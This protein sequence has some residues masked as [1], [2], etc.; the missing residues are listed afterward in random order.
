[1]MG[2]PVTEAGRPAVRRRDRELLLGAMDTKTTTIRPVSGPAPPI[3]ASTPLQHAES[4]RTAI[5]AYLLH[6][7]RQPR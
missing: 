2:G 4:H 5:D 6:N 3:A 1:M 7:R